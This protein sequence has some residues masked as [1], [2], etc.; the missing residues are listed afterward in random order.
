M[1]TTVN[2]IQ[3]DNS[4]DLYIVDSL[5]NTLTPKAGSILT[6]R[7]VADLIRAT[8]NRGKVTIKR[9]ARK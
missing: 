8:G 6:E 3:C 2:L 4:D 1:T 7:Q 9:G 5:T